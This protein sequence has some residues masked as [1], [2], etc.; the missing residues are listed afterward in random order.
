MTLGDL[1]RLYKAEQEGKQIIMREVFCD[2]Y[3][4]RDY[5]REVKLADMEL[6][7]LTRT[8]ENVYVTFYIKGENDY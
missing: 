4:C 1:I 5:E 2:D 8:E 3:H 7:A 6:S